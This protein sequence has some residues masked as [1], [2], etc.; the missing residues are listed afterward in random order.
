MAQVT[1]KGSPVRISGELPKAGSQAPDFI[2]V[3]GDLSNASLSSFPGKK[4]IL[5]IVPSL[6]TGVCALSAKKFNEEAK[7]LNDAVVLTISMD[8]PFAQDRFC[9]T[10]GLTNVIPL[11][12][13]RKK[14]FGKKYGVEILDGPL[15]G[16]YTRAVVVL[17]AQDKVVYTELIGEIGTEPDYKKALAAVH[18]PVRAPKDCDVYCNICNKTVSLKKGEEIPI[19]CGK[20]MEVID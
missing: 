12:D 19:C 7:K 2:L 3:K 4:K 9:K 16:L 14:D 15:A 18:T 11:S 13:M 10:E 6:D 20:L 8:L 5:N 17:D 1:F